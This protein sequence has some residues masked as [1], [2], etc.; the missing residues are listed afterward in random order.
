MSYEGQRPVIQWGRLWVEWD[1][2]TYTVSVTHFLPPWP[3]QRLASLALDNILD[4]FSGSVDIAVEVV[5]AEWYGPGDNASG[6]RETG[7]IRFIGLTDDWPDPV[8]LHDAVERAADQAWADA[9]S[10][11]ESSQ[12]FLRALAATE[13]HGRSVQ[14]AGRA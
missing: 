8:A 11:D 9:R 10:A 2:D 7:E 3:S 5:P 4:L 13:L 12:T 6:V 1:G 14:L